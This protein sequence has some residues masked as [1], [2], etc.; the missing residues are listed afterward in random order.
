MAELTLLRDAPSADSPAEEDF[1]AWLQAA[2][3]S[4]GVDANCQL[5]VRIVDEAESARLNERYR[6]RSGATNVLSFPA[7]LPAA[8]LAQLPSRPLGDLAICAPL[9]AR[10]ADE[11]GKKRRD[12]WA[13]L[14]IHGVLH[15]LG[16]DHQAPVEAERMES[17]EV[18][19][20]AGLGVDDP[21]A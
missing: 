13:H 21:Y 17:L 15:L 5:T 20:L 18:V 1:D 3:R 19:I 14:V 4:A 12:H 8:V 2:L 6:Q 11:Q 7:E 16:Y 10:E 9:V